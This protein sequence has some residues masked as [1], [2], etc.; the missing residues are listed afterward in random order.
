MPRAAQFNVRSNYIRER[1]SE[2]VQRTGMNATEIMEDALRGYCGPAPDPVPDGFVRKGKILVRLSGKP[3][4][5]SNE[6]VNAM[7]EESRN[8]DLFGGDDD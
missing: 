1:M 6:H 2:L 5:V 7:I 4:S 3:A 8:R